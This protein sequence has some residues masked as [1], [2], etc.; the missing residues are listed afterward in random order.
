VAAGDYYYSFHLQN[1]AGNTLGVYSE[2][3]QVAAHLTSEKT[4]TL[5]ANDINNLPATLAPPVLTSGNGS[6]TVSWTAA[7]DAADY[8]VYYAATTAKP[9]TPALTVR[10]TNSAVLNGLINGT[11]YYVWL[12]SVNIAGKAAFSEAASAK[13]IGNMGTVTVSAASGALNLTWA[14]VAGASSYDVYCDDSTTQPGTAAQNVST[15]SATING[16]MNDSTYYVWVQPVNANGRGGVSIMKSATTLV[17]V[18]FEITLNS[19]TDISISVPSVALTSGESYIFTTSGSYS[20]YQWYLN[21][22]AIGGAVTANYTLATA[23]MKLGVYEL[24][25]IAGNSA[26]EKYSG[27]CVVTITKD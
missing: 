7:A 19:P 21:G 16:L 5:S 4:I 25:V 22:A 2:M 24:S 15:N 26:G 27:R 8:E 23:S 3:V 14:S 17:G 9:A 13:P 20:S 18:L 6:L 12:K 10:D 1:A 11:N